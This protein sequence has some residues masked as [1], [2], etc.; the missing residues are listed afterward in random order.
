M[1]ELEIELFEQSHY[2]LDVAK[3]LFKEEKYPYAVFLC[4]LAIE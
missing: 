1:H 3:V 4:H 2:D